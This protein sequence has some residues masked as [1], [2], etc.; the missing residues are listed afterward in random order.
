[1]R[2][3]GERPGRSL[4]LGQC[5]ASGAIS[6]SSNPCIQIFPLERGKSLKLVMGK[7]DETRTVDA[8]SGVCGIIMYQIWLSHSKVWIYDA[9]VP[10]RQNT[11]SNLVTKTG[12]RSMTLEANIDHPTPLSTLLSISTIPDLSRHPPWTR[13]EDRARTHRARR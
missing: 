13:R 5:E 3:L 8:F 1:M 2:D 11:F 6:E 12:D 4:M 9:R 10:Q 7:Q